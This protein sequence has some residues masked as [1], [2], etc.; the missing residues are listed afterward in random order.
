MDPGLGPY[1]ADWLHLVVRWLHIAAAIA[2]I[3]TSFYFMALDYSLTPPASERAA[4]EGVG[5]ESWEIHGGGFYRIEKFRVAPARLP[6]SLHWFKWEAYTTWLSG[7][8]LLVLLYYAQA[9]TYLV[10]RSVADLAPWQ[11]VALSV[12]ILG[13]GWLAYDTLSRWL[14]DRER[15]LAVALALLVVGVVWVSSQLF[16]ARAAYIQAGAT[17]GTWMVANVFFVI[18]PGQRELIAAMLAG[19][20]PDPS[21]GIRGKQR[22]VHDNYLTLPVLFAMISQ[23]FPFTYGHPYGWL[24]LLGLMAAGAAAQ[25]FFNLRRQGRTAWGIPVL[26]LVVVVFAA[27]AVA[28][29]LGV[30][31]APLTPGESAAVRQ[32]FL[33]R[34]VACHSVRPTQVGFTAAPKGIA[35]DTAE[36]IKGNARLIYQQ[37]VA[38]RLMPLGN[39]SGMT[40]EERDLIARWFR[41]GAPAP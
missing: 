15:L 28:P 12:V 22:S 33:D 20:E 32:V 5:G 19:R 1:V 3:G 24:V 16:S 23:H 10:D 26:A 27:V 2:W 8:A 7:F 35:F 14:A 34:C 31:A 21:F 17:L 41:S 13:V 36:Q 30:G 18:I 9:E 29:R 40:E 39:L 11:A 6:A 4:R 37:V 38:T 25:H